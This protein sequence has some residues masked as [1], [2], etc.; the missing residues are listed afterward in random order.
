MFHY[1]PRPHVWKHAPAI[2]TG[3]P[4]FWYFWLGYVGTLMPPRYSYGAFI[5]WYLF[6][7]PQPAHYLLLMWPHWL[8]KSNASKVLGWVGG[9]G[10]PSVLKI[11]HIQSASFL[12]HR[13]SSIK[14][15]YIHRSSWSEA[16]KANMLAMRARSQT[17]L[18]VRVIQHEL[19]GNNSSGFAN[20]VLLLLVATGSAHGEITHWER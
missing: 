5:H 11:L 3:P 14:S 12:P 15:K 13:S 18:W 7:Y 19:S 17:L 10:D 2:N 4:W 9:S 20:I 6:S 1:D 16:S 8:G